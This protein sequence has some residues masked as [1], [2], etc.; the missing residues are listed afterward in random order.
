MDCVDALLA[1][2]PF[3]PYGM[4]MYACCMLCV[5]GCVYAF[6]VEAPV[7]GSLCCTVQHAVSSSSS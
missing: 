4:R 1:P 5:S 7:G 2:A 3:R 6:A